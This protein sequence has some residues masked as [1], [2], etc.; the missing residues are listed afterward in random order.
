MLNWFKSQGLAVN[1]AR[2]SI[3]SPEEKFGM[4]VVLLAAA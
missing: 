4:G 3:K 1:S 2:C